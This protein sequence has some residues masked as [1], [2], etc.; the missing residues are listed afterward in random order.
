MRERT[1]PFSILVRILL[2][3]MYGIPVVWIL[4]TSFKSSGDVF[5]RQSS[6]FFHPVLTA[7]QQA[8]SGALGSAFKQS[9]LI[10]VGTTVLTLA[11]AI[12]AAYGLARTSGRITTIVLGL[13]IVFQMM[14]QTAS[15]IPLFQVFGSWSLLGSTLSVVLSDTA[16]LT[17]FAVLLLRP[18]FRAVPM[19]LEEAGAIDGA[20]LGRIFF[21]IVLP[22]A[23]NGVATTGTLVFLLSWGEF[24]YAINFFLAPGQYPLSALLAQQVSAFGINWPALMALAVI[25]SIPILVVFVATYRLL[26]DGLTVGAVK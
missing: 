20:S 21:F 4:I 11:L 23:R 12:P 22:I 19:A 16:L 17:P 2:G 8:F 14:P 9:L 1:G 5:A 18:F 3:L 25:T 7:Y 6:L 10:A 13:L 24:L 26:R 15:V